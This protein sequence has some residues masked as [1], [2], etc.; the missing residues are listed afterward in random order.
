MI[1]MRINILKVF[2]KVVKEK[3]FEKTIDIITHTYNVD[4]I[5]EK[6]KIREMIRNPF[7]NIF[8]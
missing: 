1:T 3:Y 6:K 7:A 8:D 2:L 4:I 5:D